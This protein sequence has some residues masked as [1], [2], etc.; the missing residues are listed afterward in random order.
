MRDG[1]WFDWPDFERDLINDAEHAETQTVCIQEIL[2]ASPYFDRF[3]VRSYNSNAFNLRRKKGAVTAES[4]TDA[5]SCYCAADGATHKVVT[6]AKFEALCRKFAGES[7]SWRGT[8]TK[9][10]YSLLGFTAALR[11][12]DKACK[13]PR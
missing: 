13:A 6:T 9:D 12:I 2:L 11:A 3:A 5:G 7:K 4:R 1:K 10:T 8:N